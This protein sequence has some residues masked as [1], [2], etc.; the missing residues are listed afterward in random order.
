MSLDDNTRIETYTGM[1]YDFAS[2]QPEQVC[3]EDIAHAL[4]QVCRYGGHINY[5][6]SV[7]QHALLVHRLVKKHLDR[8]DLAYPALHHDSA[9]TYTG[10][11]MKPMKVA[12]EKRGL[13]TKDAFSLIER[14]A[15]VAVGGHLGIDPDLFRDPVIKEADGMALRMEAAVLKVNDG[16]TFAEAS[17]V[18]PMRP[19]PGVAEPRPTWSI[20]QHF[21][22]IHELEKP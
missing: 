2:P 6:Y 19:L 4:S 3:V 7:A 21:L 16:R 1:L 17:G 8:P 9:E 18:E 5:T 10:D 15:E 11:V 12:M 22:V 20:E 14:D 13:L